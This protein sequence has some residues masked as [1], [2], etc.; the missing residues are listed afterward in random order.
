MKRINNVSNLK[1]IVLLVII[2]IITVFF[3]YQNYSTALA[4]Y[5]VDNFKDSN[6]VITENL[7]NE[8]HSYLDKYYFEDNEKGGF[9]QKSYY[10]DVNNTFGLI[11][12]LK[13]LEEEDAYNSFINRNCPKIVKTDI[14]SL[15]MMNFIYH[16]ENLK[17][18][19]FSLSTEEIY[20]KLDKHYEISEKLFVNTNKNEPFGTKITVSSSVYLFFNNYIDLSKYD[21]TMSFVNYYQSFEFSS[22]VSNT[23]LYNSGGDII[24]A[25]KRVD[26]IDNKIKSDLRLWINDWE[27]KYESFK[28]NN[29]RDA[30]TYSEY[31]IIK[32]LLTD[33]FDEKIEDYY[34]AMKYSDQQETE[35]Y[36][37]YLLL[38]RVDDIYI[39]SQFLQ[40]VSLNINKII[41]DTEHKIIPHFDIIDTYYGVALAY[42]SN[43]ELDTQK[44]NNLL[45]KYYEIISE[46]NEPLQNS[47]YIYY[48]VKTKKF[49]GCSFNQE[50]LEKRINEILKSVEN[51]DNFSDLYTYRYLLQ[52]MSMLDMKIKNKN[53]NDITSRLKE[54]IKDDEFKYD[55]YNYYILATINHLLNEKLISKKEIINM[56]GLLLEK[57]GIKYNI[58][59]EAIP[60]VY[61]TY[62]F[63][64]LYKLYDIDY[65]ENMFQ[66]KVFIKYISQGESLTPIFY[67]DNEKSIESILY[68]LML[69]NIN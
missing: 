66:S 45:K 7:T 54:A 38:N 68:G 42:L 49:I 13:L 61:N 67:E 41:E 63:Y 37:L 21:L 39:N 43:Y 51:S 69:L 29:I 59:S 1:I 40:D 55:A 28:I 16:Q 27:K 2:M 64:L 24:L 58:S 53:K 12:M 62:Q 52:T 47:I 50:Y 30:L 9:S 23:T 32:E 17:S 15:S 44:I 56:N 25:L 6:I 33:S 57:G 35:A 31:L 20:K 3:S 10:Y 8:I 26:K 18:C 60:N 19:N 46:D 11:K 34:S 36:M 5:E 4:E 48:Y 22:D 65:T 14:D